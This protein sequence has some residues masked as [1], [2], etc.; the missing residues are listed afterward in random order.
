[1][2]S[3]AISNYQSNDLDFEFFS[4]PICGRFIILRPLIKEGL[5]IIVRPSGSTSAVFQD[6][7][8]AVL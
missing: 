6:V 8:L 2:A 1:M 3:T 7:V 4:A 5:W